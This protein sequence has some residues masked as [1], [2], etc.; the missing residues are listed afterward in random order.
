MYFFLII[1]ICFLSRLHRLKCHICYI[2][3]SNN[4]F[5]ASSSLFR[6]HCTQSQLIF[7]LFFQYTYN[8]SL[9]L[10]FFLNFSL[11]NA[12]VLQKSLYILFSIFYKKRAIFIVLTANSFRFCIF[13][14][15]FSNN[16]L[17]F[18]RY[19]CIIYIQRVHMFIYFR[20]FVLPCVFLF[21]L[22]SLNFIEPVLRTC[23]NK[24]NRTTKI[25]FNYQC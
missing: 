11:P 22:V 20:L 17:I 8:F 13:F 2:Y 15:Y 19:V 4:F 23:I 1:Y 12:N 16:S 25:K 3:I 24:H 21:F 9:K 10:I 5:C 18:N 6:I 7:F 14:T